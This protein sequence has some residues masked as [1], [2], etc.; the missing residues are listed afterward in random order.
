MGIAASAGAKQILIGAAFL[1]G[2]SAA[3]GLFEDLSALIATSVGS[4]RLT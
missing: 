3:S 2:N 1:V 4:Y